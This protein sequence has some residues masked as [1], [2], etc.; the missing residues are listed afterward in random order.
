MLNLNA[1]HFDKWQEWERMPTCI[2][3]IQKLFVDDQAVATDLDIFAKELEKTTIVLLSDF[4]QYTNSNIHV[5][6]LIEGECRM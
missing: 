3:M 4:F 1:R 5:K 2:L 6:K